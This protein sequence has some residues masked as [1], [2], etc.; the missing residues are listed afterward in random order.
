MTKKTITQK[1][2][3][4]VNQ[5]PAEGITTAALK[6]QVPDLTKAQI[7]KLLK[8]S[9]EIREEG[10]AA[11]AGARNNPAHVWKPVQHGLQP[12]WNRR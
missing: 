9:D 7:V 5:H 2:V 6:E 8:A 3:E 12:P 4:I 11:D 1:L 10:A